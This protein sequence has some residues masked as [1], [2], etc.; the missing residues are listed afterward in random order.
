MKK[1]NNESALHNQEIIMGSINNVVIIGRLG[2]DPEEI[3]D[4]CIVNIATDRPNRKN[5]SEDELK[6]ITNCHTAVVLGKQSEFVLAYMKTGSLVAIIGELQTSAYEDKD[7]IKKYSTSIIV[8]NFQSLERKKVSEIK[9]EIK[10][11]LDV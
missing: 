8:S 3:T 7:G 1:K 2:S 5:R 4:G 11:N 6:T 10:N 9:D